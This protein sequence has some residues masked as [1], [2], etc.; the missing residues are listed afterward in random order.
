MP[1][2][3]VLGSQA[4]LA[5]ATSYAN[6]RPTGPGVPA[7]APTW[8]ESFKTL[9]PAT[10]A[11][12][13]TARWGATD[14][15]WQP[16]NRGFRDPAGPGTYNA[17]PGELPGHSPFIVGPLAGATGGR[18][19]TIRSVR[20]RPEWASI[21]AASMTAQG[22]DGPVPPWVGGFLATNP[23]VAGQKFLHGYYAYRLRLAVPGT[24]DAGGPGMFPAAWW[25]ATSGQTDPDGKGGAEF[26]AMEVFGHAAGNV[27]NGTA[28]RRW[29]NATTGVQTEYGPPIDVY[30]ATVDMT[31]WHVFGVDWQPTYVQYYLDGQPMGAP[32]TGTDA[33]WYTAPMG[34]RLN[35]AMDGS[36]FPVKSGASTPDELH[37][38]V[39][40][41]ARW[42]QT[43]WD[44][45]TTP[46][47]ATGPVTVDEFTGTTGTAWS[48]STWTVLTSAG[49]A[50]TQ[51][52]GKGRA[53][54]G[55]AGSYADK[56]QAQTTATFTGGEYLYDVTITSKAEYTLALMAHA[57][58]SV[59]DWSHMPQ[60][61]YWLRFLPLTNAVDYVKHVNYAATTLATGTLS[62]VVGDVVHVAIRPGAGVYLWKNAAARPATPTLPSTDATY[63]AGHAGVGIQGGS[64]AAVTSTDVDR[65]VWQP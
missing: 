53:A 44:A 45:P 65:V 26:D 34:F 11:T 47:P 50:Y 38:H 19:L 21:I 56:G 55:A 15:N 36:W 35:Y 27:V 46:P 52:A 48:A 1:T 12:V 2:R 16:P 30:Q 60:H 17:T 7:A 32:I 42:D 20:T 23:R 41:A 49:G 25:Y 6:P 5:V 24:T 3:G 63:T 33:S 43:G 10:T 62:T 8:L 28:H 59:V 54:T 58:G 40:W 57:T 13:S 37:M 51:Q 14:L 18:G 22:Q 31:R 29:V 9:T 4:R 61:G 64:A 39:D